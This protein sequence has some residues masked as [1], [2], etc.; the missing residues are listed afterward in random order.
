MKQR[1]SLA[2]LG[3]GMAAAVLAASLS[4]CTVVGL[5]NGEILFGG[6]Q[7]SESTPT[8]AF[9]EEFDPDAFVASI[10][11]E[12]AMP[13]FEEQAVEFEVVRAALLEDFEGACEQ[14]GVLSNDKGS[15]VFVVN[16]SG[17]V[18]QVNRESRNGVAALEIANNGSPFTAGLQI[19]PVYQGASL[20][21][22]LT[23][24]K[25]SDYKNQIVFSGISSALNSKVD[26]DIVT[27][28]CI[29]E[30]AGKTVEFTGAFSLK[31]KDGEIIITPVA[32]TVKG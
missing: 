29:D 32:L 7:V 25:F 5:E 24:I 12:E 9:D 17:V 2:F 11:E 4:G 23:F 30:A 21:D 18:T 13:A 22:A 10:W 19:G 6:K 14:Y 28:A 1:K 3:L 27:P 26:T 31:D 8:N 16:G 15:W 20:R